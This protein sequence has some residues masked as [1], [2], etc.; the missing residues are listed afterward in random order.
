MLPDKWLSG[1]AEGVVVYAVSAL[2]VLSASATV[3]PSA[4]VSR[5]SVPVL[6]VRAN[7]L[8]GARPVR[9]FAVELPC[10]TGSLHDGSG[11]PTTMSSRRLHG[12]LY[13]R[14]RAVESAAPAVL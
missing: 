14:L 7:V 11:P 5:L 2:P 12:A 13:S 3:L 10:D 8:S 9:R 6:V 1:G 4:S